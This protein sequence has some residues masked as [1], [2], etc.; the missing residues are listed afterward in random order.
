MEEKQIIE[1]PHS[2]KFAM[3]AKG[4]VSAEVKCYG[5]TPGEAL[6]RA[7]DLLA[8]VEIVIKQKNNLE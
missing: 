8:Q 6:K 5:S 1:Q 4:L 7:C 3:N 2:V